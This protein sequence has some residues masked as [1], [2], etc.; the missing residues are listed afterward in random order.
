MVRA[1]RPRPRSS[2]RP[3]TRSSA[4]SSRVTP[5][6]SASA[7]TTPRSRCPTAPT[8]PIRPSACAAGSLRA[9]RDLR[10]S[11]RRLRCPNCGHARPRSTSPPARRAAR[12][13]RHRRSS[14]AGTSARARPAGPLQRRQRVRRVRARDR[15]GRRP[16]AAAT[17]SASRAPAFGR[18]QRLRVGD[19]DAV[20]L[21]SRT[22]RARTRRCERC[23]EPRRRVLLLALN[24]RIA[25]GRDV[26][27]IWDVDFELALPRAGHVVCSGTR[28]ADIALRAKY[29]GVPGAASRSCPTAQPRSTARWS[30]PIGRHGVR[31]ADLHRDA[32]A[33]ARRRRAGPR[34]ALLGGD[35]RDDHDLP[36]YPSS[37]PSTPTAATSTCSSSAARGAGIDYRVEPL[38]ARRPTSTRAPP[39]CT[40]SAAARIATSCSLRKTCSATAA[41]PHAAVAERRRLLAVCGGYQLPGTA[42][43]GTTA[44][45][46]PASACSTSRRVAGPRG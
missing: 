24:D 27:W 26:S 35:G 28:A 31:A 9:T 20:L 1:S 43:S 15:A 44:A 32:R 46:C 45:R 29:A 30:W 14:S 8:P 33:A 36:V 11:P 21:L 19:R 39:T 3:T 25:D 42:T 2:S 18:F 37:S 13:R 17:A 34:P 6:R 22:R 41:D 23:A 16:W 40:C 4:S 7:S 38:R 5:R 10:R 12:A